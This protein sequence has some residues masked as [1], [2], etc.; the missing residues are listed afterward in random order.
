MAN[1]NFTDA[2]ISGVPK[3]PQHTPIEDRL[4]IRRNII[5]CSKQ[6]LDAGDADVGRCL[7]VPA[8]TE[9]INV[10]LR[11]ITAE[12]ANGTVD[13]GYGTDVDYWGNAVH[14]DATGVALT[15]LYK[16]STWD[17]GQV[18]DNEMTT[19][20]VTVSGAVLGDVVQC[21]IAVDLVDSI[22][23]GYVSTSDTVTI[24]VQNVSGSAVN[25]ASSTFYIYVDKAPRSRQ[26]LHFS[27]ADT[28]D[29]KATTD[30]ADVDIDGA[31]FEII[32]LM[33]RSLDTY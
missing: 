26:P 23:T 18:A 1:Y 32:A 29:V 3:P 33:R 30:V 31:K 16:T 21:S 25:L 19:V 4:F 9:V 15:Q 6:N 5:D 13:V 2:S 24:T 14:L 11:V 27:A 10:W 12:T 22:F 28:I 8:N 7:N 20:D 17:A